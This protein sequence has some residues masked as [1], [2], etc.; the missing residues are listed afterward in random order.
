MQDHLTFL[1]FS[2]YFINPEQYSL[3]R[4][5]RIEQFWKLIQSK[6]MPTVFNAKIDDHQ[7]FTNGKNPQPLASQSFYFDVRVDEM[8]IKNLREYYINYTPMVSIGSEFI[9]DGKKEIVPYVVG[10]SLMQKYGGKGPPPAGM[11]Y[12]NIRAI[13]PHPVKDDTLRVGVTLFK[14]ETKNY[15]KEAL[16][17]IE[18]TSKVFPISNMLTSYLQ[19]AHILVD[20]IDLIFQIG[21]TQA[22]IGKI[23]D[24]KV[25]QDSGF[26]VVIDTDPSEIDEKKLM[27]VDNQLYYGDSY[28]ERKKFTQAAYILYSIN[29]MEK[30][31][32]TDSLSFHPYFMKSKSEASSIGKDWVKDILPNLSLL[33]QAIITSPDLTD[34]QEKTLLKDYVD[35][36][37]KIFEYTNKE[38]G[39]PEIQQIHESGTSLVKAYSLM[40]T[41]KS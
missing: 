17:L 12:S 3:I 18:N 16:A 22:I 37:T 1:G 31:K 20:G 13:G 35:N 21:N 33:S 5:V 28:A 7:V 2:I 14:N 26:H 30:R 19:L 6:K 11:I 23:A 41:N 25:P 38:L 34:E 24:Y 4:M 8:Y 29:L 32:D 36:V 27:V 9:Y 10:P 15:A 40:Q 39:K